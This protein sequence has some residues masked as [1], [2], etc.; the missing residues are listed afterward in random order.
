MMLGKKSKSSSRK[1][2]IGIL[3]RKVSVRL[4]TLDVGNLKKI[5]K[6]KF[7]FYNLNMRKDALQRKNLIKGLLIR[8]ILLDF[9]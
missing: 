3:L 8:K 6:K 4:Y 2:L 7:L 9:V 5:L 1:I